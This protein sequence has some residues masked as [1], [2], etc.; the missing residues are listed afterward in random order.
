MSTVSW[1]FSFL[2]FYTLEYY[3]SILGI[4]I[5][6]S[7]NQPLLLYTLNNNEAAIVPK[8]LRSHSPIHLSYGLRPAHGA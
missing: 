8:T 5:P 6:E 2:H 7:L 4:E 3:G 1:Q